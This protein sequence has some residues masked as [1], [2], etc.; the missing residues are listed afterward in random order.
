MDINVLIGGAAGQGMDTL[1][2]IL[3]NIL[4][5]NGFE[6]FTIRD[7][8]SR[9]RGGHNFVQVRFS[10]RKITSHRNA[11]DFIIALNEETIGLHRKKLSRDGVIICDQEITISDESILKFP[12]KDTALASGNAKTFG[13]CAVGVLLKL[14][15]LNLD[16]TNEVFTKMF[17][18]E[19]AE[20]NYA[21]LKSGY[22]LPK[23]S[24][25]N[26]KSKANDRRILLNGNDAI[27]LGA[28]AADCRFYSAYPMSP[29][30]S[31]MNFLASKMEESKIVVEQAE[32]EIAA[33]NMAIGASY[34][35]A[36]SMTGTSGGGFALMVEG[37]GL[38]A[39]LEVPLVIANIQRPGPTTGFPT[40]SEQA[41]LKFAISAAQGEFPRMVI[42]LKNPEDAF[43][44]T[45]RAFNLA[46]KFQIPVIIMSDQY[47]ADYTT[48]IEPLDFNKVTVERHISQE[49][50]SNDNRY[51][52]YK[53]T[54]SGISPRIIPGK[55]DGQV[56]LVDSDEH[57]ESG[58]ITESAEMR[59]IMNDKRLRKMEYLFKE[60]QEPELIGDKNAE[61]LILAWG[62]LHGPTCE[63]IEILNKKKKNNYKALVFGD[64]WPLPTSLLMKMSENS[65]NIINVEQ[66][67][68]G[69]LASIVMEV[70]GIKCNKSILKYDGRPINSFEIAERLLTEVEK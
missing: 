38:S 31:I 16:N 65:K 43:Y 62:S 56:V 47:L 64:L 42:A 54:E 28:L 11:L 34:A 39:M 14:F 4:K 20:L 10:D 12:L 63:A 9:I 33:I 66:N 48:T 57:D 5:R 30:T 58:H 69:Q 32:D 21:V 29:S 67:S 3:E 46:D 26:L 24:K 40:R 6:I 22:L 2:A 18:T 19:I 55:V 23:Q 8:M 61:N 36:R 37:L 49:E 35:G 13:T 41:D 27:A 25:L 59:V 52:R 15:N 68:T 51:S 45:I 17:N 70:T 1:A 53:V 50:Y 44:Q 60:L 7:L